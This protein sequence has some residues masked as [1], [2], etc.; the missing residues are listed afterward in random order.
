MRMGV[1]LQMME[2]NF[3]QKLEYQDRWDSSLDAPCDC[4]YN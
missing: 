4:D 1:R 2:I 3:Y